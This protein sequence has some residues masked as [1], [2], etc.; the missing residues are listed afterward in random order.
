MHVMA[1]LM[2]LAAGQARPPPPDAAAMRMAAAG[3]GLPLDWLVFGRDADGDY[4]DPSTA[5]RPVPIPDVTILCF[6]DWARDAHARLGFLSEPAPGP[7]PLATLP[8]AAIEGAIVAARDCGLLVRLDPHDEQT[9]LLM[10]RRDP[11]AAPLACMRAWLNA[12]GLGGNAG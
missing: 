4:A 6:I 10:A 1:I 12:H 7:Q 5:V 11:P 3:C 8:T 2:L 9:G